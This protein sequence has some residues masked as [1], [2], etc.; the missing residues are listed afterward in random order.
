M[1]LDSVVP[2]V[3]VAAERT[4]QPDSPDARAVGLEAAAYSGAPIAPRC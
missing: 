2:A 4:H 3:P 1:V